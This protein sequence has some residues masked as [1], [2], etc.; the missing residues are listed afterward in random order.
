MATYTR[1]ARVQ[2]PFD[3]VWA[4]HSDERGLVALTPDWMNLDVERV[5]GPAGETDPEILE[6]GARIEATMRPL[7]IGPRQSWTSVITE[8]G[9]GDGT[10]YFIDTMEDGPFPQW[11]HTHRFFADG[12]DTIISDRIEYRLPG[13]RVGERVSPLA[14]VGFEPMFSYRHRK[15]KQLLE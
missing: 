12:D 7:N 10:A 15:T 11:E 9:E 6:E 4:F 5:I 1:E 14:V 13:G 8:R 3:E 2:A